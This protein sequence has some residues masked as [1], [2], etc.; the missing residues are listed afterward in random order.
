MTDQETADIQ[1]LEEFIPELEKAIRATRRLQGHC[2]TCGPVKQI[3]PIG[4]A[5]ELGELA[6][7][8][9]EARLSLKTKVFSETRPTGSNIRLY[10]TDA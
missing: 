6:S 9:N 1:T 10:F 3:S 5:R 2:E 7:V 4:M 8:L